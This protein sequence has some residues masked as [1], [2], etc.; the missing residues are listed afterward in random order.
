LR[1][2]AAKCV[3][4]PNPISAFFALMGGVYTGFTEEQAE[5]ITDASRDALSQL[6]TKE[7][8]DNRLTALELRL[9]IKLG[10][11]V[12]VAVGVVAALGKLL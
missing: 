8:L 4:L 9:T 6:V 1:L 3:G 12:T 11:L 10:A 5:A 2:C 7:D